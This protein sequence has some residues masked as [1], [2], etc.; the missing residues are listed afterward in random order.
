MSQPT[1]GN[2]PIDRLIDN[3]ANAKAIY[4]VERS[5]MLFIKD[6]GVPHAFFHAGAL[7]AP[8]TRRIQTYTKPP[9]CITSLPS[10]WETAYSKERL[11]KVDTVLQ[12]AFRSVSPIRWDEV[13]RSLA[14]DIAQDFGL[15]NGVV[16]PV[17]G[18]DGNFGVFGVILD[19]G[20]SD[21][22]RF[23]DSNKNDI[24]LA[25]HYVF[26]ALTKIEAN[27]FQRMDLT[28]RELEI[29]RWAAGGKTAWEIGEILSISERT[30]ENHLRNIR[31]K[32][33][34]PTKLQAV[35]RALPLLLTKSNAVSVSLINE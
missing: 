9:L 27:Q 11:N 29:L 32:L 24:F 14:S 25:A 1:T 20:N 28:P 35:L 5:L 18:A 2:V 6:I 33:G 19:S 30:A 12:N 21:A 4:Q 7:S 22:N 13:G 16:I 23:L 34:V 31:E 8:G 3:L 17:H 15:K 10:G 26:D